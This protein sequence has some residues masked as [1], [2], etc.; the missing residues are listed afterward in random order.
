MHGHHCLALKE[1][2]QKALKDKGLQE[3][4]AAFCA[5]RQQNRADGVARLPEASATPRCTR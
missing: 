2:A 3:A 1:N 4:L 5:A